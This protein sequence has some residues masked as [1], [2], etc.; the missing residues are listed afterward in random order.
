[1]PLAPELKRNDSPNSGIQ[2]LPSLF[3][4]PTS[5]KLIVNPAAGKNPEALPLTKTA[6]PGYS[7]PQSGL[8]QNLYASQANTNPFNAP[9]MSPEEMNTFQKAISNSN[10]LGFI[11]KVYGILTVQMLITTLFVALTIWSKRIQE[12]Q[13]K[14]TPT[15]AVTFV[16][17]FVSLYALAC[18]P[19][20]SR[21]V[22]INYILLFLF[23]ISMSYLVGFISSKYSTTI[24][25]TAALLTALMMVGL[26]TY[27]CYTK[28]DFT[29]CGGL[30]FSMSFVFIGMIFVGIFVSSKFYHAVISAFALVLFSMYIIYDT[31]LIVGKHSQKFMIDDYILAALTLY[32]DVINLFLTILKILGSLKSS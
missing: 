7:L 28:T 20:I 5:K 11:R 31:Q 1:M 8:D 30:L 16:V 6:G 22:P 13:S 9:P 21:R 2:R 14:S 15:M 12:F 19:K 3:A 17:Y 24:V 4:A 10:R 27:A 18:Y 23:T 26:T 32:L 25:I 29:M